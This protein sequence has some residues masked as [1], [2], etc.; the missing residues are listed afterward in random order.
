M[1]WTLILSIDGDN[2]GALELVGGGGGGNYINTILIKSFKMTNLKLKRATMM[3][4]V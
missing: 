2:C 3:G 1:R 4:C